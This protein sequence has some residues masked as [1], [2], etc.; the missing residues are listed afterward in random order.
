VEAIA[1]RESGEAAYN[2]VK[3]AEAAA[4]AR[5]RPGEFFA[6]TAKRV[7]YFWFFPAD[8]PVRTP[9]L[10][11]L[12]NV[13]AILGLSHLRQI[14]RTA[15]RVFVAFGLVFP[16]PYYFL[17][18]DARYHLPVCSTLFFLAAC[19]VHSV[20]AVSVHSARAPIPLVPVS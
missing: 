8:L 2:R 13:M 5:A 10:Y 9:W 6:L 15:W 4:W 3:L 19:G 18:L 20:R 12:L 11:Y 1:V 17:Q 16:L 14:N 7:W